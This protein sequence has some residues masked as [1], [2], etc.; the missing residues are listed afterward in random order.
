[1]L[2]LSSK[3]KVT[4][5][6]NELQLMSGVRQSGGTQC[7]KVKRG[8]GASNPIDSHQVTPRPYLPDKNTSVER[9]RDPE[10]QARKGERNA[11]E[12]QGGERGREGGERRWSS[13]AVDTV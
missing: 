12:D 7:E 9:L 1:M 3:S 2:N 6:E 5:C 13:E 4:A 8:E 10:V 11:R